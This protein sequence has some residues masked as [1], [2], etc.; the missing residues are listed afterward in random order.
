MRENNWQA[1]ANERGTIVDRRRRDLP[2]INDQNNEIDLR[3]MRRCEALDLDK[4]PVMDLA[5]R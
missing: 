4:V 3:F 2:K 1:D 5:R